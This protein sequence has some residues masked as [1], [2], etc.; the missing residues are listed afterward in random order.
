MIEHEH[1]MSAFELTPSEL[2]A[3]D[4]FVYKMSYKDFTDYL[5][6]P[7]ATDQKTYDLEGV[8]VIV[9]IPQN[10]PGIQIEPRILYDTPMQQVVQAGEDDEEEEEE[11][12]TTDE[13]VPREIQQGRGM[14]M[15]NDIN[16]VAQ[17]IL[18]AALQLPEEEDQNQEE[19][20]SQNVSISHHTN[21]GATYVF[22]FN[23]NY[24]SPGPL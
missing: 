8:D 1:H 16:D 22:T 15:G 4:G 9:R 5:L 23:Q 7:R 11:E 24:Y 3:D 13:N 2:R 19:N 18:Q 21:N 10:F 20:D 12:D 14:R 6:S 17:N